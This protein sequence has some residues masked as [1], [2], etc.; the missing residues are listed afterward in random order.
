[1][2]ALWYFFLFVMKFVTNFIIKWLCIL[3]MPL[4]PKFEDEQI[5]GDIQDIKEPQEIKFKV[6]EDIKS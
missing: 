1:M 3:Q 4:S 2:F 6:F 5:T